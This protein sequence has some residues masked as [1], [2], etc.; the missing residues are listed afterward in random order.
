MK[1]TTH[2]E[3]KG[4]VMKTIK[5]GD[6]ARI[7]SVMQRYIKWLKEK[8]NIVDYAKE[9]FDVDKETKEKA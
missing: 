4:Y 7:R 6:K 2:E 5:T 1:L 9:L 3:I 8:D